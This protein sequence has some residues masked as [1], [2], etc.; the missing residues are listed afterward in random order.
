[1]KSYH[2][3]AFGAGAMRRQRER[4]SYD[5]YQEHAAAQPPPDGLTTDEIAFLRQRDSFYLASVGEN[6]WPYVQHRGGPP[7]F[8]RVLDVHTI[9]W[10]ERSGNRQYVSAGN[11]DANDR[12]ALVA[13]DYPNRRRLKLYGRATYET[14]PDPKLAALFASDEAYEAIVVVTVEAFDWNCPKFIT[15]RYTAAQVRSI[16]E[17]LQARIAELEALVTT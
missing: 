4:G 9:A 17:P 1:M 2:E 3:I 12:V 7:G 13:V 5:R 14:A 8:V 6:G 15:P 10:A 11:L 16:V